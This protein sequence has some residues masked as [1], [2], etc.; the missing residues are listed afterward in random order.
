MFYRIAADALVVVHGLWLVF[1]VLGALLALR[2]PK[3]LWGHAPAVAW[4]ALIEFA[5]WVCPLTPW[6]NR[7]RRLGGETGY[8]G[9]FIE[10]YV[11]AIVYPEGLTREIQIGLGVG[12]L[13]LNAGLY[14][15]VWRHRRTR[16]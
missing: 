15:W 2:W 16:S 1:V 10:R 13:V 12:V 9:A 5:G 6:E 4:G 7:L 11:T 14:W 3:V 8:S